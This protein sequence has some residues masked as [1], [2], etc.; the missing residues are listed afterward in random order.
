MDRK[1][2]KS[3]KF[4]FSPRS[5]SFHYR[6]PNAICIYYKFQISLKSQLPNPVTFSIFTDT[7]T[8]PPLNYHN[9]RPCLHFHFAENSKTFYTFTNG[10]HFSSVSFFLTNIKNKNR[11]PRFAFSKLIKLVFLPKSYFL[12]RH[13]IQTTLSRGT[14]PHLSCSQIW[15]LSFLHTIF[16]LLWR[17]KFVLDSSL[18]VLPDCRVVE[19]LEL[20][21]FNDFQRQ[22]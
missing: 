3:L 22:R 19:T 10:I 8:S 9:Y 18:R 20:M 6:H 11:L 7:T 5:F 13:N 1:P 15:T 14:L 16:Q 2:I 12:L 4:R 21:T 17:K